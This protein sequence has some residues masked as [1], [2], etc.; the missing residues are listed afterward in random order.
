PDGSLSYPADQPCTPEEVARKR[1]FR[2]QQG[3]DFP[4]IADVDP[5][6]GFFITEPLSR[7]AIRSNAQEYQFISK[8]NYSLA[9]EHQ[10]QATFSGTPF[11]SE[12]RGLN[13]DPVALTR[14][15]SR[16]TTDVALNWTSK[17]NDSKTQLEATVGWHRSSFE[18][19]AK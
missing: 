19:G 17:F 15:T 7:R 8:L 12:V 9:D 18:S 14:Q 5:E 4:V 6:T 1:E 11:N 10:G 3:A 16:V 13:G 2:S